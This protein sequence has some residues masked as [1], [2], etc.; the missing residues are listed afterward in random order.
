MLPDIPQG[1]DTKVFYNKRKRTFRLQRKTDPV[2]PVREQP[3][4]DADATPVP[5]IPAESEAVTAKV[6]YPEDLDQEIEPECAEE[7]DDESQLAAASAGK[8]GDTLLPGVPANADGEVECFAV[9]NKLNEPVHAKV[10]A[11][12]ASLIRR[13]RNSMEGLVADTKKTFGKV[14]D[15]VGQTFKSA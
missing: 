5:A 7:I 12:N 13:L 15:T 8:S 10:S 14:V 2:V 1:E 11:S 3:A 6:S 4:A 9:E